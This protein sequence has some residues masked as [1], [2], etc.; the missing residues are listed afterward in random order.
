MICAP[1]LLS[2]KWLIIPLAPPLARSV[3]TLP[4][5][6]DP[7]APLHPRAHAIVTTQGKSGHL[8]NHFADLLAQAGLRTKTLHRKT[9][10]KDRGVR[11][12]QEPKLSFTACVTPASLC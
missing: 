9:A 6:D 4:A 1:S 11:P 2:G 7:R 3:E 5:A 10:D 12:D 8:S